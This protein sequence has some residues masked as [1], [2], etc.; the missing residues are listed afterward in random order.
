MKCSLKQ[1]TGQLA[2]AVLP[3]YLV[4]RQ[5]I[6]LHNQACDAIRLAAKQQGY[7]EREVLTVTSQFDWS[8]LMVSQTSLSL[9]AEKKLI[10]CHFPNDKINKAAATAI[11]NYLQA[12]D[13]HTRL[14][15][16]IEKFTP[17][18][19]RSQCGKMI[20]E[21]GCIIQCWPIQKQEMPAFIQQ[22]AKQLTLC[23]DKPAITLLSEYYQGNCLSLEQML[24]SLS[25]S[26]ADAPI[27]A[28]LAKQAITDQSQFDVFALADS[29]LQTDVKAS[30][31]MLQQL[32]AT[33][34]AP[35]LML[36]AL[37]KD[38]QVL[39][40]L[41]AAKHDRTQCQAILRDNG[42]WQ[43][44]IP[45]FRHAVQGLQ[46]ED[47]ARLQDLLWHCELAV[48]GVKAPT[49]FKTY[50]TDYIVALAGKPILQEAAYGG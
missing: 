46:V 26:Y 50:L 40:Q 41:I 4:T 12:N 23:L 30:L 19:S 42:V 2:Q 15:I 38:W 33:G 32:L 43:K 25:L 37:V 17:A 27:D 35:T 47:I 49:Y 3:V 48:K 22:R 28:E 13:S 6:L 36:W 45:L 31:H 7:S 5:E 1:L 24:M 20:D 39:A 14:L 21:R 10:E 11:V 16:S 34:V 18:L 9:F 8:Q 29:V 44:R